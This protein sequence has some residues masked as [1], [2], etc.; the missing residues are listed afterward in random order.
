LDDVVGN[1]C[2]PCRARL[3]VCGWNA[4]TAGAPQ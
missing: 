2:Y 1:I 3:A 4:S